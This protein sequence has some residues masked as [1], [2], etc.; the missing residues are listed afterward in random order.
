MISRDIGAQITGRAAGAADVTAAGSGDNT[1]VSGPYIDRRGFLS[2]KLVIHYKAVLQQDET[3]SIA[4][5][6]QDADSTGGSGLGDFGN[7]V[8]NAV[9]ATGGAGGSTEEGVV[10]LDVDLSGAKQYVR[11][12][13]TPDLS[14]SGTDTAIVSAVLILGGADVIPAA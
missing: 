8:A 5:N 11:A 3:I 10:E 9:Q 4:A 2:A 7:A 12:Q 1:E 14:A 6:L 13:F